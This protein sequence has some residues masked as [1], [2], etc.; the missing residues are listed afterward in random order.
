MTDMREWAEEML[1]DINPEAL[2]MDWFDEAIIGVTTGQPGM[3]AV[4]VYDEDLI[5]RKI[6]EDGTSDEDAWDHYGFN[7]Q[8]AYVGPHT[9][10]IVKR[11]SEL[12]GEVTGAPAELER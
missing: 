11:P 6:M 3:E 4:V 12:G 2:F 10:I 8:G 9:P 5:I 7:I 1:E